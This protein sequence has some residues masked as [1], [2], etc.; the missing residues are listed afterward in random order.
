MSDTARLQL[1]KRP[2]LSIRTLQ[3]DKAHTN[4]T[5]VGALWIVHIQD[6]SL[7]NWKFFLDP[8][9]PKFCQLGEVTS[10]DVA[11][12]SW[13]TAKL[14]A[15]WWGVQTYC[16]A[17]SI[18]NLQFL[19]ETPQV[20]TGVN[21]LVGTNQDKKSD[22]VAI[23]RPQGSYL[24][25]PSFLRW[26]M[27]IGCTGPYTLGRCLRKCLCMHTRN[28]KGAYAG[29]FLDL[30]LGAYAGASAGFFVGWCTW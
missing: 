8:I 9:S 16:T 26:V 28:G 1:R 29:I 17:P 27:F 21:T 19:T 12:H 30:T 4:N 10:I 3:N 14:T 7:L 6:F 20:R 13:P 23:I 18:L 11:L 15:E 24:Q 2:D 5:A 25:F 22:P